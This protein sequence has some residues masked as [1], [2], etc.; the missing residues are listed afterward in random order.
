[1]S[2]KDSFNCACNDNSFSIVPKRKIETWQENAFWCSGTMTMLEYDGTTK[3]VYN[4]F[5]LQE[6]SDII[7]EN[8]K[9]ETYLQC[10]ATAGNCL[11]PAHPIFDQQQVKKLPI[12]LLV[13]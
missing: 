10:V 6:L 7:S 3:Y 2:A 1:M 4:P 13:K 11:P 8:N 5:S 9:F 12:F